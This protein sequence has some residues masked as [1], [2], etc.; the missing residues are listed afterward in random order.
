M[1]NTTALVPMS[2]I[3]ANLPRGQKVENARRNLK[4]KPEKT[5]T[6]SVELTNNNMLS[7]NNG[8]MYN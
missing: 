2:P 8:F 3:H 4:E 7:V 1:N 6:S 5:Y